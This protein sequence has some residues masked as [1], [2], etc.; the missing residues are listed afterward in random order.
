[1]ASLPSQNY[2]FDGGEFM[3][4]SG[5][6][7]YWTTVPGL[8]SLDTFEDRQAGKQSFKLTFALG[9]DGQGIPFH[10]HQDAYSLQ[11]HGRKRWA[12]Y[13]PHKMT[14][15]GF[16]V[17][18]SHTTWLQNQINVK[19]F[20]PPTWECVQEPGDVLYVPEGFFHATA[21]F[22][23]SVAVTHQASGS[24]SMPPTAWGFSL[25]A[26]QASDAKKGIEL[27]KRAIKLD[28]SNAHLW[29]V[30]GMLEGKEHRWGEAVKSLRKAV[31]LNPMCPQAR[32]HL[33]VALH[34]LGRTDEVQVVDQD[35][36]QFGDV[37]QAS[38]QFYDKI[39]SMQDGSSASSKSEL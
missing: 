35:A 30:R 26:R 1:M 13:A 3:N 20:V 12:I 39:L 15:T 10:W 6:D 5:L 8:D 25:S 2:L 33:M 17:F 38:R 21:C 11:L 18:E 19:N 28:T 16:S 7:R 9:G 22:G 4:Q 24:I 36:K 23:E 34:R 27:I 31:M 14:S 37:Q 29:V 32:A